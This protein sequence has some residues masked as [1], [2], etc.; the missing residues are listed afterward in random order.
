MC[1]H[2]DQR[3][4]LRLRVTGTAT[5][6]AQ[7]RWLL[8]KGIGAGGSRMVETPARLF[9]TE[10]SSG[11]QRLIKPITTLDQRLEEKAERLRAEALITPPGSERDKLLHMA[12]Q[13]ETA[14]HMQDW[15]SSRG[16][17]SPK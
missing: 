8:A 17:Q 6:A 7:Q 15:L 1:I 10:W 11:M 3:T 16:L 13:T 4:G 12:R 5:G 2:Y 9:L 14:A